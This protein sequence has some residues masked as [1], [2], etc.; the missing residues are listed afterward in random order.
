MSKVAG[1]VL[2]GGASRRMGRDKAT[3][4]VGGIP[5]ARRVAGSLTAA[6][7]APIAYVGGDHDAL[8]ALGHTVIAD[9]WPGEGPLGGLLTALRWSPAARIFVA[10]C[11]LPRLTETTVSTLLAAVPGDAHAVL[12]FTDRIEPLCAIW[13]VEHTAP[14][15]QAAFDAGERSIRHALRGIPVRRVEFGDDP[16]LRDVDTEADLGD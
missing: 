3:L 1:C 14:A 10:S 5:M 9:R 13:D 15:L 8:A 6:G 11:D 16:A 4:E 2:T 7:I 12:A